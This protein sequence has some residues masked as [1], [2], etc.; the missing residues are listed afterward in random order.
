MEHRCGGRKEK[1]KE[2]EKTKGQKNR[3]SV[4]QTKN[5]NKACEGSGLQGGPGRRVRGPRGPSLTKQASDPTAGASAGTP[6][7]LPAPGARALRSCRRPGR[8][9]AWSPNTAATRAPAR[10]PAA[11]VRTPS[12]GAAAAAPQPAAPGG[13]S[14][15]VTRGTDARRRADTRAT[16]PGTRGADTQGGSGDARGRLPPTPGATARRSPCPGAPPGTKRPQH[17]ATG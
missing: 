9:P 3:G 15:P 14:G 17:G 7:A 11:A 13:G 16:P 10:P 1:P 5:E 6:H 12:G 2:E 8:T 4:R